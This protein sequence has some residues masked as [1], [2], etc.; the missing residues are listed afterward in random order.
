[1]QQKKSIVASWFSTLLWVLML[2]PLFSHGQCQFPDN[3]F[4]DREEI[5]YVISYCWGPIWIDAGAVVFKTNLEERF[6]KTVWHLTSTGRTFRS[7]DFL[8]KVRDTYES[9]I[10]TSTYQT[11]EFRRYIYENGY[12]LQNSSWFDY[13]RRLIFSNTKINDA[14]MTLDTIKM[15][16]CMFDMLS[17]VYYIRALNPDSLEKSGEIPV[18][19]AIDDSTYQIDVKLLGRETVKHPDGT[20][21]ACNKYSAIMVEGTIFAKDQ[22]AFVWVSDDANKIPIYIE[23][24]IL[25]GSVKAYLKEAKG[26]KQTPL[27]VKPTK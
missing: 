14:P 6:G 22:E 3:A 12:Q 23:A 16:G 15:I 19:V 26:L 13:L 5:S 11:I 24:K 21:Y 10:D 2:I 18:V 27:I 7:Y 17:A 25:V 4:T 8:F 9:W 20:L 1:M